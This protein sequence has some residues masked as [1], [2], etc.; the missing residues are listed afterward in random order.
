MKELTFGQV[1]DLITNTCRAVDIRAIAFK[2]N[3]EWQCAVAVA[4]LT[5]RS[6]EKVKEDQKALKERLGDVGGEN[7]IILFDSLP[8]SELDSLL[9]RIRENR[10]SVAGRD[11]MLKSTG[12]DLVSERVLEYSNLS[13]SD[14]D[15]LY[16]YYEVMLL[17]ESEPRK[18]LDAAG[19]TGPSLGI[20]SVDVLQSWLGASVFGSTVVVVIAIPVYAQIYH[21]LHLKSG[22][23]QAQFSAHNWLLNRCK[24]FGILR[25]GY[26]QSPVE[27]RELQL[28]QVA[29]SEDI[30]TGIVTGVFSIDPTRTDAQVEFQ[31]LDTQFGVLCKRGGLVLHM[32]SPDQTPLYT[33][34]SCFEGG[35]NLENYLLN[36][37]GKRADSQFTSA[38][39]WLLE[40]CAF[41]VLNLSSLPEAEH[42]RVEGKEEGSCDIL[43][44]LE[45]GNTSAVVLIDC[46]TA[47]PQR[48]KLA[49]IRL[50]GEEIAKQAASLFQKL[51]VTVR[52]VVA[53]SKNV[54]E[55]RNPEF[56]PTDTYM[57]DQSNLRVL[58]ELIRA[59][60]REQAQRTVCDW[61]SLPYPSSLTR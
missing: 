20:E 47:V 32:L 5:Y 43:A 29:H 34:F 61:L 10:L 22:V 24:R 2:A 58:L 21:P 42:L 1:K 49:R 25:L 59:G 16:P 52:P 45:L 13:Q 15:M 33:S 35:K 26:N 7:V 50:T 53:T 14:P 36:P 39:S 38:V 6:T 44:A 8:I 46:T 57:L 28:E 3:S 19:V 17:S 23:V 9:A 56:L 11:L 12:K 60:N 27:R 41:R 31:F 30:T 54:P 40:L 18:L 48:D 37:R 55:L 51:Q 4:R